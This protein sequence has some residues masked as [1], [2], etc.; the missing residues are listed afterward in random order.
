MR[1]LFVSHTHTLGGGA[2]RSFLSLIENLDRAQYDIHVLVPGRGAFTHALESRQIPYTAARY[3]RWIA[4]RGSIPQMMVR[5]A[6]NAVGWPLLMM[7][8][9]ALDADLVF[10]NTLTSPVGARLAREMGVPHIFHAREFVHEDMGADFIGGTARAMQLIDQTTAK[11]IC[12][13]A[14]AREK[15]ARYLPPEKLTVIYNGFPELDGTPP[16]PRT[17]RPNA[18]KLKLCIV[19]AVSPRKGQMEAARALA[20]L[21]PPPSPLPASGE[22]K[23]MPLLSDSLLHSQESKDEESNPHP[24]PLSL[25][26]RGENQNTRIDATLTI[27]GTGEADYIAAVKRE[28]ENLGVAERIHWMGQ[29]AD[30][31]AIY[32]ESDI[33]L[34]P[35]TCEAFGRVA[36]ESLAAGCPVIA[37]DAGGLPEI[38]VD[39]ETG[40]LYP[41]GDVDALA[42]QISRLAGDSALYAA[43]SQRGI[44]SVYA[45]FGLKQYVAAVEGVIW[46]VGENSFRVS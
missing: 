13:S 37:T 29:V 3:G 36:V 19:G 24:Q 17:E 43:L 2:A 45:R 20:K 30:A 12:N 22:G 8:K 35:S 16:A 6:V 10:S 40:L 7:K 1:I 9:N 25:M 5:S 28:A 39:G 31:A 23:Q 14:A 38:V 21:S 32:R 27:V 15:W 33:T 11:I 26:A 44:E 4:R 46:T 41:P 34:M 18:E 42:R